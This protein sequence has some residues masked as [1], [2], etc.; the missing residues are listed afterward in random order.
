MRKVRFVKGS[1]M[2]RLGLA[3][4]HVKV[5]SVE[6]TCKGW[7]CF[8]YVFKIRSVEDTWPRLSLSKTHG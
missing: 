6:G 8:K 2:I 3:K 1:Y 7:I 5:R 4:A